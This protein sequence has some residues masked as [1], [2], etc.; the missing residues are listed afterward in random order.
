MNLNDD[1][2]QRGVSSME[3]F[4]FVLK[5][6]LFSCLIAI[7]SQTQIEGETIENKAYAFLQHSPTAHWVRAAADGGI[8]LIRQGADYTQ[9]FIQDKLSG[10]SVSAPKISNPNTGFFRKLETKKTQQKSSVESEL[11]VEDNSEDRF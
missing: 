5:C 6:L 1:Y 9:E 4:K 7:F 11:S 10:S 3:E 8:K 2:L